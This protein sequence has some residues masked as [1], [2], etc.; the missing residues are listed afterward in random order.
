M[1]RNVIVFTALSFVIAIC[2]I[3]AITISLETD[4][5]W[6]C[7][8][9]LPDEPVTFSVIMNNDDFTRGAMTLPLVFFSYDSTITSITHIDIG[10]LGST[11]SI[12]LLNGFEPGGFWNITNQLYEFSWDGDLPDGIC[13]M[14]SGQSPGG[15]WV[16]GLG[17]QAYIQ[18]KIRFEQEGYFCIDTSSFGEPYEWLFETPSPEFIGP[19]CWQVLAPP[20]MP[21]ITFWQ[22]PTRLWTTHNRPFT[23][24]FEAYHFLWDPVRFVLHSG[25]GTIDT[26]AYYDAH[27]TYDPDISEAGD[28]LLLR[29]KAYSTCV[30]WVY[31]T[32]D[33]DLI[34]ISACGDINGDMNVNILDVSSLIEYLYKDGP[35][36]NYYYHADV[37][38]SDN[39]NVLD[40]TYLIN[41]LYKNGPEPACRRIRDDF[42]VSVGSWWKYKRQDGLTGQFD[43]ILVSM[44]DRSERTLTFSDTTLTQTVSIMADTVLCTGIYPDA[45]SIFPL[46]VGSNW[47][48]ESNNSADTV[49]SVSAVPVPAGAFDDTYQIRRRWSCGENCLAVHNEWSVRGVGAI[50]L[51]LQQYDSVEGTQIDEMWE[52]IEYHI[53]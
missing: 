16:A 24:T 20:N 43:T 25:P 27:W 48:N 15:G 34:V 17:S 52:L 41:Y 32:A 9:T 49:I 40:A 8:T 30:P 42:P 35:S 1:K 13:F 5:M 47:V 46:S 10:A 26:L 7:M 23:Y 4:Y 45:M 2:Q 3:Q 11:G 29:V 22:C 18:F 19:Y 51:S 53:D 44:A 21:L 14:A 39:V 31:A 33:V 50:K 28:T 36:P 38:L 6:G 37:D 12:S